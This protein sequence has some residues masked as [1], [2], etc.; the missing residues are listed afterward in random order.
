[1]VLFKTR[2]EELHQI[3]QLYYSRDADT[4]LGKM[5][6]LLEQSGA[7]ELWYRFNNGIRG[8]CDQ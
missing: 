3:P 7:D 5:P 2:K 6:R 4:K 1:M 8:K